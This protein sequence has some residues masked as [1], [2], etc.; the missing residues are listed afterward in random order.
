MLRPQNAEFHRVC[1]SSKRMPSSFLLLI[2]RLTPL[3]ANARSALFPIRLPHAGKRDHPRQRLS[4]HHHQRT[5][6]DRS[7]Y[8]AVPRPVPAL[9]DPL[10][11]RQQTLF[12]F[13]VEHSD[14]G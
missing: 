1:V 4:H 14:R 9:L 3:Y 10:T 6:S 5:G 12:D 13:D 8:W 7:V 11:Y 2:A